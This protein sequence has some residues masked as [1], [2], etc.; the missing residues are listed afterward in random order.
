MYTHRKFYIEL[1]ADAVSK[2]TGP[3]SVPQV[4]LEVFRK[5]LLRLW[6]LNLLEL[7][8]ESEWEHPSFIMSKKD[9]TVS[10]INNLR[11]LNKE[12]KQK[13]YPLPIIAHILCRRTG[14][15]S[16]TNYTFQCKTTLSN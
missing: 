6:E 9:G 10:W 12:I 16:F 2:H 15:K 3:Y 4:N 5:E 13:V 14:Y 11:E 7:M 8:G 1:L